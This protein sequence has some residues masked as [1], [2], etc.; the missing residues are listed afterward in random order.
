MDAKLEISLLYDFYGA[1]MPASQ[2]RVIELYVNDDL[3]LSEVADILGI[4]R[5]GVRDSLNRASSK[6][7]SYEQKLGLLRQYRERMSAADRIRA[8]VGAILAR[9]DDEEIA[10]QCESILRSTDMMN[11]REDTNGI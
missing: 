1:L 9:T 4:S 8:S 7:R 10:A 11:E 6:L 5:Q 3:S 2:Q